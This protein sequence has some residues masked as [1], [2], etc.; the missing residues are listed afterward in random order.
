[1]L[2]DVLEI[3]GALHLNIVIKLWATMVNALQTDMKIYVKGYDIVWVSAGYHKPYSCPI[4]LCEFAVTLKYTGHEL[5]GSSLAQ[6]L[7]YEFILML[8]TACVERLLP[9]WRL[10]LLYQLRGVWAWAWSRTSVKP[11]R[12]VL[13]A[14][15]TVKFQL[16]KSC[17]VKEWGRTLIS[18][19]IRSRLAWRA[20]VGFCDVKTA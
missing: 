5:N 10:L 7:M 12:P 11:W 3:A 4:F 16:E 1:M 9:A 14:V 8:V 20:C 19:L 2:H 13:L 15:C 18:A 6:F 17:W